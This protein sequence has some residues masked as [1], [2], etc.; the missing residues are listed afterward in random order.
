[1]TVKFV[2]YLFSEFERSNYFGRSL[3]LLTIVST[4]W[5]HARLMRDNEANNREKFIDHK[6]S[7]CV[8][9]YV[10]GGCGVIYS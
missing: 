6:H 7:N 4:S 1:M 8:W 3:G 5:S 10:R 9:T 2:T